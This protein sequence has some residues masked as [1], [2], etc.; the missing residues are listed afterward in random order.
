MDAVEKEV[1]GED[2]RPDASRPDEN[3]LVIEGLVGNTLL[4]S[5][6]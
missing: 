1:R 3:Q 2:A 6:G 4:Q 5:Y